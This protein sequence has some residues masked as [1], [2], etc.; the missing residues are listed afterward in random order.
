MDNIRF[1]IVAFFYVIKHPELLKTFK[2]EFFSE[3]TINTIFNHVKE[4][5]NQYHTEPTAEQ[6]T[7]LVKLSGD[8]TDLQE[9]SIK[10]LWKN[11]SDLA[12][13]SN[14]WL[15]E[16]VAGWGQW[17]SFYTGLEKTIAYIQSLPKSISFA[18]TEDY[19]TRAKSIFTTGASFNA[20]QSDGHDFFDLAN[21]Q[22]T[23]LNTRTTGYNFMDLCL[24]GGYANKTLV[25]LMGSPKVGKSM[26]LCNL[27][28]QSVKN[29]YNTLYI[30]LEMSYQLVAQ[31]IGSNLFNININE[32][33]EIAKDTNELQKRVTA[34][35]MGNIG[36][37]YG[38]FIIEEF[39]TSTATANDIESFALGL[40]QKLSTPEHP[41][42]FHN[43]YIDYVN[44]MR[45]QKNP[46]SENTYQKIKSICE[47]VRACA[48]RNDW[49][50]I[51]VTQ[52]NRQ[53]M[54][55]SDLNMASV[56][57]SAG[58]IATVD[59]L[60]GI[61]R[62]PVMMAE[63]CYYLKAIALRNSSHMGDKKR[64]NLEPNYL[65]ISEDMTE[66]IIPEN[67]EIP[68]PMKSA[69]AYAVQKTAAGQQVPENFQIQQP[70]FS[71]P[72][73]GSQLGLT[74]TQLQGR[75]LFGV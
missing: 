55:A 44:I 6:I 56:S 21:H 66:D 45:D 46:N 38:A 60:F 53:G 30:S 50:I 52:T 20:L 40:E 59:A 34:A 71:Q 57:E 7:E 25:C 8:D 35:N 13:Y 26:W 39:P 37:H 2:K 15:S 68:Q 23:A 47:D 17:R 63:G 3:P 51:S 33:N 43:I 12:Q 42:K 65:R 67:M 72:N 62:T 31:R 29:G 16:N 28:A 75:S 49:C 54:D 27:A 36:Q 32:Y 4:F 61:I 18:S 69:T 58:L 14:D 70:I 41:F 48:Q 11:E 1:E 74:E 22:Q 9:D 24:N 19:I 73:N 64:F 5:V 10:M